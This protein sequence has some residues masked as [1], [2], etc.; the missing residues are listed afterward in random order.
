[1]R[2]SQRRQQP[3][4]GIEP[5]ATTIERGNDGEARAVAYLIRAGM[6]IVERNFRSKL[7]ELDIVARDRGVLVF[8]EVRSR[9]GYTHGTAIEMVN[10]HKQRKVTRVA[11]S[12]IATRRPHFT[13]ARFDVIGITGD[14]VVHIRDAWRLGD[15]L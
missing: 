10:V 9:G 7:G 15:A 8:V 11:W 13:T 14:E 3:F 5:R 1:M 2:D 4:A 6:R 12:Y